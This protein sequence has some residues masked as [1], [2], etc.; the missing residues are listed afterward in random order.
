MNFVAFQFSEIRHPDTKKVMTKRGGEQ[1]A[2]EA[3]THT[4][5]P[6]DASQDKPRNVDTG[7]FQLHENTGP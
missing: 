2:D 6:T 4:T 3:R 7:K 1:R 5:S